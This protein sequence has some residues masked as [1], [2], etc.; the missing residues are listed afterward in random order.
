[1]DSNFI[2]FFFSSRTLPIIGPCV[3]IVGRRDVFH[4]IAEK[5]VAEKAVAEKAVAEKVVAEKAVAEKAVAEKAVA[6]K[7]VAGMQLLKRQWLKRQLL[8]RYVTNTRHFVGIPD[9]VLMSYLF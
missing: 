5:V 7:A 8:K 1:M 2:V 6:E 3:R 9:G 4:Q